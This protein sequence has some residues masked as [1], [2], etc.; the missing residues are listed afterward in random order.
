MFA[1]EQAFLR[2]V[3][4]SLRK[5]YDCGDDYGMP[6]SINRYDEV[7][8][9][10]YVH[11]Q[12]QPD[13]MAVPAI[14]FGMRPTPVDR[15]RVLE[16]GCGCGANLIP[17]AVRSPESHFVGIDLSGRQIDQGQA[18]VDAMGLDNIELRA[19]HSRFP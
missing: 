18:V 5:G 15:C 3:L 12:T 2:V 8:Y 7:P 11:A 4:Y 1:A 17:M 14:L 13:R 19:Q 10:G 16:L 9:P 6:Q